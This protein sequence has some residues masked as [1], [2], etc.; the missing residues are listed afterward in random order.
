MSQK[1]YE[2]DSEHFNLNIFKSFTIIMSKINGMSLI[3]VLE[4]LI[5]L[6]VL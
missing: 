2:T 6:Y 5:Y 4:A 3:W 1:S